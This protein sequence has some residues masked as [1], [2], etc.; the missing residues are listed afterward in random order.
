MIVN[1]FSG[2]RSSGM[3]TSMMPNSAIHVFC[4]TGL[5]HPLTLD[6]VRDCADNWDI[7]IVWLEYAGR[8]KY[9]IIDHETASRHGQ[10]FEILIKERKF[11]PNARM[12]FCTSALKVDVIFQYLEEMG[13]D[14]WEMAVGMRADE[15]ARVAKM[16]GK[17][18]Y[19]VPLA[20]KGITKADVQAFWKAQPFDLGIPS[21]MS[22]CSLCFLKGYK[23][24]QSMIHMEPELADWWI[25]QEEAV[26]GRFRNDQP[27]F[28][29]M[30]M[31]ATDAI[32]FD[33]EV[34]ESIPCFCGD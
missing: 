17:D 8:K 16:R 2:G 6:F 33:F 11:L 34:D 5:E 28:A 9:K 14:D 32:G 7:D 18:N 25:A 20:D 29:D 13:I 12:R 1:S 30:K 24:K 26:G 31:I 23:L 15:P 21:H 3:M 27:S 10:P 4:N 19:I 22:N